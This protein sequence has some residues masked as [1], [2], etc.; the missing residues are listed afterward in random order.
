MNNFKTTHKIA[1]LPGDGV[2]QEVM[3][4]TV[5][6]LEAV[7]KKYKLTFEVNEFP[8]GLSAYEKCGDY[9]PRET[10]DGCVS[11]DA[12]LFGA[13]GASEARGREVILDLRKQFNF[14]CNIRPVV[15]YSKEENFDF[16]IVRELSSGIYFGKQQ[17][18]L[19]KGLNDDAFAQ[20]SSEY[21]VSQI[22]RIARTAFQISSTRKKQ[23]TSVDKSNVLATSRLWKKVVTDVAKEF[24]DVLLQHMLVDTA[25]YKIVK[26]PSCFDVMLTENLF[27]DILS[28]E[29]AGI[30]GSLGLMP[31]ASLNEEGYGLYEPI[32]G[33]APDIAGKNIANPIGMI[34]SLA[35]CLRYSFQL[36]EA[37]ECIENAVAS[38]LKDG[39]GTRDMDCE[40]EVSTD[41]MGDL[42]VAYI[43]TKN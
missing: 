15:D 38:V 17:E 36:Y 37:A 25:A 26:N 4:E 19:Y 32:H 8:V 10:L 41:R 1:L 29:A 35:L 16:I 22:A 27:G 3:E 14:F 43:L 24:Q 28:D 9:L 13:T 20:D 11:C 42:V 12:I 18:A 23:V 39:Y 33:S 40:R 7:E 30:V 2:G 6:V 31:S 34:L 5:K 21:S